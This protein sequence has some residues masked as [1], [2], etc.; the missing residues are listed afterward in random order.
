MVEFYGTDYIANSMLYHAYRQRLLDVVVGPESNEELKE[1][2]V[3][4]CQVGFCI[5]EFLGS[6]GE[7]YPNREVEIRF[8]ASKVIQ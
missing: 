6:L 2:L 7:Q 4:T 1:L 3:T 8:S 5:G